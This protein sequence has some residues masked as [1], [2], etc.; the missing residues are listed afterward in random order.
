VGLLLAALCA[1]TALADGGPHV[2][3]L[4]NGTN[5]MG[6]TCGACHR[7][8]TASGPNLIN[9]ASDTALCMTCHGPAG[10]GATTDVSDGVLN[11]TSQGLRGGGF[12]Y[13]L[14][15][16]SWTST[17]A[18]PAVS[19]PTTS[20]HQIDGVTDVTMW[21][22]GALGTPNAGTT[23]TLECT[24]C[25]NPHGNG[26]Y[27]I[28]KPI[29][30]QSGATGGINVADGQGLSYTV[31]KTNNRYFGDSYTGWPWTYSM[32]QW[33]AQCHTRYDADNT[34]ADGLGGPGHTDSGDAIY[35]FRHMTR[36]ENWLNCQ[37][38][39]TGANGTGRAPDPLGVGS[40]GFSHEPV[41]L[42]C[43][44]AHG[45]AATMNISAGSVPWPNGSLTPGGNSRS[46]LLRLDNR[47]VCQ[48]CHDPTK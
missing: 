47:G 21:G 46:A 27:R 2:V 15:D 16:S 48:G 38:C 11:G 43:H 35:K 23:V 10:M 24:S 1:A 32:T 28:L 25:H 22:N 31:F 45:T 39:H 29:P 12:S 37:V 42:S 30:E 17:V 9:A 7:A 13:A 8:H 41:C 5:P 20:A 3:S 18:N 6:G 36:F 19:R 40:S 33:C 34:S 26:N 14:M 44:V 4:N